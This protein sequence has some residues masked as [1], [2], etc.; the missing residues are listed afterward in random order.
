MSSK[1]FVST[2]GIRQLNGFD[3]CISLSELGIKSF[4]LSGGKYSNSSL[5]LFLLEI[6][7]I[8]FQSSYICYSH[9]RDEIQ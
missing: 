1:V 4:E 8:M 9:Y 6:F 5:K 2:G 7:G 3:A